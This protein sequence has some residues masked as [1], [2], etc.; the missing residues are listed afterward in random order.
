MT[1]LYDVGVKSTTGLDG[2]GKELIRET[3]KV[4]RSALSKA[5]TV[6]AR[7]YRDKLSKRSRGGPS[8]PGDP[9]ARL[10][11]ALRSTV[12]KDRPR[13]DG[14]KFTVAVGIGIGKAK[15]RRVEELKGK[16]VNV[17]EYAALLEHGG[18]FH[19]DGRRYPPRPFAR[20]AE[21]ETEA[22]IVSILEAILR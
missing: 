20:P 14:D 3:R 5:S 18:V 4:A 10:T 16:G 1:Q 2:L 12:G 8:A 9:P 17:F 7:R 13:R 19:A 21:E 22:E 6:L 11:G 15:A